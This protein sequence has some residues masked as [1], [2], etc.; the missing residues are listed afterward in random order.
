M[1]I[2]KGDLVYITTGRE[3]GLTGRVRQ[4]SP[5]SNRVVIEGRNIVQRHLRQGPQGQEGG[6]LPKEA[7]VDASN[8][9]LYSEQIK[10]GVRVRARFVGADNALFAT[11]ALAEESF[12]GK[13]PEHIRKVRFAPKTGEIFE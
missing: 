8:V 10:R 5:K 7:S 4:V 2:K 11:K 9:M 13:A 12:G 3:R 6:I 1:R